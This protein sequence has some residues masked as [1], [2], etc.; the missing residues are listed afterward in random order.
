M[1]ET[2]LDGGG[3]IYVP[4]R[5]ALRKMAQRALIRPNKAVSWATR[6]NG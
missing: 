4:S 5:C 6:K 2:F 1:S 3:W